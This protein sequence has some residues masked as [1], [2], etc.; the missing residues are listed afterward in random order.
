MGWEFGVLLILVAVLLAFLAPRFLPRGPRGALAS[1]TLLV[2]GVSPRPDDAV[3][4]QYVT[5]TGVI[6]GPTVNEYTVYGRM[7][8]DVDQWPSTGQVL[9]V[10]YSPKNPD[11]WNFALEEPPED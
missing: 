9:P 11:N 5:I 8:V 7:A 6:N 2:T 1:G 10:V 4:E 3:G